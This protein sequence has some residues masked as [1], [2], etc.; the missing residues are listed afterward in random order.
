MPQGP[1]Y[2]DDVIIGILFDYLEHA[3]LESYTRAVWDKAVEAA[4]KFGTHL[5]R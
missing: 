4:A 1:R 2:P 5:Q 3:I